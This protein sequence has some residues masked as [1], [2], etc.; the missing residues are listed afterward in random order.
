[1]SRIPWSVKLT[2]KM[3]NGMHSSPARYAFEF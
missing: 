3:N 2:D 1:M